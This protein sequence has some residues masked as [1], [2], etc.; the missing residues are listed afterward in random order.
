MRCA[1]RR[2]RANRRAPRPSVT[3]SFY[4]W[5]RPVA[6]GIVTPG[7]LFASLAVLVAVVFWIWALFFAP[8]ESINKVEDRA[9]AARAEGIC[10]P[11]KVELS[12]LEAEA[13]EDLGV[14][15]ALVVQSTDLLAAMLDDLVAVLPEDDKGRA[16]VPQWELEYRTLLEDRYRYAERLRRGEDG[17]FTETAVNGIPITERIETFAADN[18]M[19]SCGPPR[20]SVL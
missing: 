3:P 12:V 17:P 13:S 9:W 1:L 16:I 2:A 6:S 15:A 7:R 5:D 18:E 19:S 4:Q 8:K 10:A 14:R 20:G 11:V